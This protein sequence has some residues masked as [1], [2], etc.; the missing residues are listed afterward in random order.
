M[1][2]RNGKRIRYSEKAVEVLLTAFEKGATD[3]HAAEAVGID[4]STVYK[5]FKVHPGLKGKVE[6]AKQ[7]F[8]DDQAAA[9]LSD[10]EECQQLA[11]SYTLRLLRG[12]ITKTKTRYNGIGR[13]EF[14]DVE[15][16]NPSDRLLERFLHLSDGDQSFNLTIGLAEPEIENSEPEDEDN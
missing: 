8:E 3:Q 14:K 7:K 2:Q 12:E 16:V 5:W 11:K 4:R 6:V 15:E 10:L 1:A 13:I 9:A